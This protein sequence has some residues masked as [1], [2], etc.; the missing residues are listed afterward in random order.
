MRLALDAGRPVRA[1]R[2]VEDLWP[3]A[4]GTRRNT[5][6][7]KVSQLRRAL[8]DPAALT[9]GPGRLHP[10]RRARAGGRAAR[11]C[12]SP[13][14]ARRSS[15]RATPPRPR[16]P[17]GRG[18]RC[19][20][21]RSC[22]PRARPS[23][24]LPHRV[25]LEEARLRLV[26]DELAARLALGAAGELIGE[27]ESLVAVHPL[28][29]RLWALLITALY[30]AGRQA[31]ALAA[32][33]PGDPAARRR[34][35]RR[36]RAPSWRPLEQRVLAHDP[37]LDR[38]APAADGRRRG[39]VPRAGHPARR[40]RR[41]ARRAARE[42]WRAHRLVTLVGPAGVGKT[43]LATEAA[44]A[45]RCPGRRVAGAAGGRPVRGRAAV[46]ARRRRP[47]RRAAAGGR[48]RR[49]AR[50]RPAARPRQLRAPGRGRSPR[51][52]R[53]CS[54][55]HRGCGCWPPASGR[56]ASTARW[57]GRSPRCRRPTRSRCS[58]SAPPNAGRRS[59]SPPRPHPAVAQLCRALDCLPLAIELAAARA[60]ILT[61]AG[62]RPAA[63]RPLHPARRP[64]LGPTR[65]PAHARRG[66][67]LEL[68]PA[69][70][71]RPARPLGARPVP[72]RGHDAR[73]R[74]RPGRARRARRRRPSTSWNG[75]STGRWSPSTPA[76][77]GRH[78]L[79]PAGQ[80]PRLRRRPGGRGRAPPTSPRTRWSTGSRGSAD[81]VAAQ[82]RG[83]GQA[84]QVAVTAAERAD[85]RR[86]AGPRPRPRSRAGLRIAVG[87]G[88][89]W[90]L[91]DDG[92]AAARLRAARH[93]RRHR[94][95]R[96]S[97]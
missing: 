24:V 84:A 72:R 63:R 25:R 55:P 85:D 75:W 17:A 61:R 80:R 52:S 1:E 4:T 74:A 20:D 73:R 40:P 45:Q 68:R 91:L 58:R 47:R 64:H 77:T 7:A 13:T 6:Q 43:R 71:R 48:R 3:D 70:P 93:R 30:R 65:A 33:P 86:R 26:E 38:P 42:T 97:G 16:P 89:A 57:C 44:A 28:R 56:S 79:P 83:P 11:R 54:T 29:E 53:R 9:G 78:P 36:S 10:R 2:L 22:P 49:A 32:L 23:W 92:A 14:Q 76:G 19:S 62:D 67:G 21:P 27:L 34:A 12:G 8:G 95:R 51:S 37:A 87:F 69:V 35:R 96:T 41:R 18:S 66:P 94:A 81:A 88:W 31:D 5:L 39:N 60:R 15:P 82:V 90:V 46:G 59:R 50:G